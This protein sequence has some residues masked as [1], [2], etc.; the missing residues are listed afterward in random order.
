MHVFP[1]LLLLLKSFVVGLVITC[2]TLTTPLRIPVLV[3]RFG[4]VLLS[5]VIATYT[6]SAVGFTYVCMPI[7][8]HAALVRA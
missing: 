8:M 6:T 4:F 7:H 5:V 2:A 1:V 3:L